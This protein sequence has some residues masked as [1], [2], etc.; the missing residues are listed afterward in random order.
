MLKGWR[1]CGG[2][3]VVC[4]LDQ[5]EGLTTVTVTVG[6]VAVTVV[7]VTPRQEHAL[8]YLS[9][10]EQADAYV[11]MVTATAGGARVV[12]G[13]VDAVIVTVVTLFGISK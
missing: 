2:M 13:A 11:G 9:L 7:A 6:V 12:C 10:P 4:L 8:L 5:K 3:L 1:S